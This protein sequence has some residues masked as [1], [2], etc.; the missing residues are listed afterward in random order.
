MDYCSC[1]DICDS[2]ITVEQS[3]AI[4]IC[5]EECSIKYVLHIQMIMSSSECRRFYVLCTDAVLK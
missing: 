4:H 1:V 3:V 2:E 5:Y